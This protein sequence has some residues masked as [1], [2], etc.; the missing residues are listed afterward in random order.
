[1]GCRGCALA[2][3]GQGHKPQEAHA[4]YVILPVIQILLSLHT[5]DGRIESTIILTSKLH[6]ICGKLQQ[7]DGYSGEYSNILKGYHVN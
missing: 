2:Y 1:M 7:V 5:L 4:P 6:S 3:M